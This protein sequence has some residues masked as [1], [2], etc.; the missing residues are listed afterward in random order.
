[1][2][3][4]LKGVYKLGLLSNSMSPYFHTISPGLGLDKIFDEILISSEIGYVKPEPEAFQ[5]MLKSLD[6][7]PSESLLID[8][9]TLNVKAAKE[10]GMS[11][12]VF[13]TVGELQELLK[14]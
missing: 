7:I 3:K 6:V 5:E 12:Y 4:E 13:T 11:G 2:I 1:M 9:S 10:L 8:D 14:N